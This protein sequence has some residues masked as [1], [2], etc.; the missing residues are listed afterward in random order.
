MSNNA[1]LR[2]A[3]KLTIAVIGWATRWQRSAE[4]IALQGHGRGGM[5]PDAQ[6]RKEGPFALQETGFQS[7]PC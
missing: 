7:E 2:P 1:A 3:A 5:L 4:E 6:E